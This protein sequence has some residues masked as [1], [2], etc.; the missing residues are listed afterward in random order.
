MKYYLLFCILVLGVG[1]TNAQTWQRVYENPLLVNG[2]ARCRGVVILSDTVYAAEQLV[3]LSPDSSV[4]IRAY[5]STHSIEDGHT[6]QYRDVMDSEYV[7]SAWYDFLWGYDQLF[8]S[9]N[10][11]IY[12]VV[13]EENSTDLP[14]LN[15][16]VL[17]VDK[18]MNLI[19][20]WPIQSI[21]GDLLLI[22]NGCRRNTNGDI[23]AYGSRSHTGQ[24]EIDAPNGFL[25]KF[26]A[27]GEQEWF[28]TYEHT[29]RG[30]GA[31]FLSDG[32]I[33]L[34][35]GCL[36]QL[37]PKMV[38]KTDDQGTEQWRMNWGGPYTTLDTHC[39]EMYD[40]SILAVADMAGYSDLGVENHWIE[41]RNLSDLGNSY[42]LNNSKVYYP[43]SWSRNI[44]VRGV[45]RSSDSSV[46]TWGT[47]SSLQGANPL[48]DGVNYDRPYHRGFLFKLNEELDS[49][50]MRTYYYPDD[51]TYQCYD[52][53]EIADVAPLADGGFIT[54]GTAT[55]HSVGSVPQMWLMRLDEYGCL[56]PGCQNVSVSEIAMGFENTMSVYPNP[57]TDRCMVVFNSD[58]IKTIERQHPQTELIVTD[59]NGHQ[60]HRQTLSAV[61]NGQRVELDFSAYSSGSYQVHWISGSMWLD[62]LMVVKK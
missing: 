24:T 62:T 4:Y 52:E 43:I 48:P 26:N 58:R 20:Q 45:D 22:P 5:L 28:Q 16:H 56:E 57:V 37:E 51:F 21:A 41:I 47:A 32:D 42:T 15:S 54:C 49:L 40:G 55:R 1:Q 14:I 34:S 39:L 3:G 46:I 25:T 38:I 31:V 18:N 13:L 35:A 50:W 59:L 8:N 11:T 29:T 61:Q 12:L 27:I 30:T 7:T 53:Y 19:S 33:L 10:D 9:G 60:L 36:S 6:I 23:F 44:F 2:T 17:Q